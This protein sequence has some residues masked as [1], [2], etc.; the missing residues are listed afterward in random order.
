[1]SFNLNLSSRFVVFL[2]CHSLLRTSSV[3]VDLYDDVIVAI[4]PFNRV[5]IN[6]RSFYKARSVSCD[7]LFA[8]CPH[9]YSP[10]DRVDD[11]VKLLCSRKRWHLVGTSS[12]RQVISL[13]GQIKRI[14]A[15]HGSRC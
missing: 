15:E 10:G 7:D 5:D 11:Q 12:S 1:M 6:E 14:K 13:V 4:F 2:S 3:L 8:C 9:G